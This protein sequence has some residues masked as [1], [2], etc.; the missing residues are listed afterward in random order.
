MQNGK[1]SRVAEFGEHPA[2]RIIEVVR[3]THRLIGVTREDGGIEVLRAARLC[4]KAD[5]ARTARDRDNLIIFDNAAAKVSQDARDVFPAATAHCSP[6]RTLERLKQPVVGEKAR[7]GRER[8]RQ[9]LARRCRPDGSTHRYDVGG[10]ESLRISARRK[11]LAERHARRCV[12]SVGCARLSKEA[13]KIAHQLPVRNADEVA[14][15][16]D[17]P[18]QS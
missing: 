4:H 16:P 5:A 9:H 3:D 2:R 7:E 13:E 6:G 12:D 1:V 10:D 8:K 14:R 15:L 17:Q 11:P 18:G